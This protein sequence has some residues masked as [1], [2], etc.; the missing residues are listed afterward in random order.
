MIEAREFTGF[1]PETLRFFRDLAA[2]ND[3][4]WFESHRSEYEEHILTPARSLVLVLGRRLRKTAARVQADPRVNQSLFRLNRDTRFS[5]D[6]TPYKT[7]LALWFWEGPGP[8]MEC[9]GYYFHLEP[10]RLM[11]GAG[12][13]RFPDR[14]IEEYRRSVVHPK[15]GPALA[16]ALDRVTGGGLF[17]IGGRHFKKTP[18]DF[19]PSHKNA[20]LL[21]YNGL[22]AGTETPVPEELFSDLLVDYCLDRFEK[23]RPLH[24]WLLAL[25]QRAA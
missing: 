15:H 24:Q 1:K 18:R 9:S 12:V 6:K 19:D 20:D 2:N 25:T 11:L 21:L 5:R 16:K 13:Y 14:M 22:Y 3:K 23:M 7:H 10:Q 4:L 17:T 8:R